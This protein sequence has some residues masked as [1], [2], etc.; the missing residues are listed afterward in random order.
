MYDVFLEFQYILNYSKLV[1][2][3]SL[4][5]ASITKYVALFL[6]ILDILIIHNYNS[7]NTISSKVTLKD[8]HILLLLF[9][10]SN[11]FILECERNKNSI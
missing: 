11:E 1:S 4:S 6:S 8:P 5:M 10:Y 9:I 7:K 2:T 3:L